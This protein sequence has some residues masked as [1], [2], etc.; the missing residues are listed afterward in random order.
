M[1][2]RKTKIIAQKLEQEDF[3]KENKHHKYYCLFHDNKKTTVWTKLSHSIKEYGDPLLNLMAKQLSLTNKELNEFLD[4][5]INHDNLV[6]T[7]KE[8]RDI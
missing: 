5:N 2:P 6:Q 7:L 3:R 1:K 8:R 4:C